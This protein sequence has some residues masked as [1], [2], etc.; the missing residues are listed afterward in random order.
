MT[1]STLETDEVFLARLRASMTLA[2]VQGTRAELQDA[3][4]ALVRYHVAAGVHCAG[5][6]LSVRGGWRFQVLRVC[7]WL[8]RKTGHEVIE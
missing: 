5:L 6:V 4:Q 7:M 1:G 3:Y 2:P 8:I